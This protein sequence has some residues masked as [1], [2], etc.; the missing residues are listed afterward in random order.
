MA[1]PIVST[2]V[3][4]VSLYVREGYSGFIVGVDDSEGLANGIGR[5]IDEADLRQ[6]F[7][8][9]SRE[10]ALQKLDLKRCA[11]RHFVAYSSMMRVMNDG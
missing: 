6:K 9:R 4:D 11:E 2:D 5:L 7:G 8:Q 10:T 3:G 1:K